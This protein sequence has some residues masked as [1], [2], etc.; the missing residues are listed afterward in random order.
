MNIIELKDE[1]SE[2]RMEKQSFLNDTYLWVSVARDAIRELPGE[3][4]IFKT[5]K[6]R[7]ASENKII[8]RENREKV[9]N[10]IINKD[11]FN[12]AFVT[13]IT[14]IEDYL[15]KIMKLILQFDSKRLKY[16]IQGVNMITNI[17]VVEFID[18]SREDM[19]N[20]IINQRLESLFYASPKKQ[21]EYLDK[22]L[23]VKLEEELW[24]KWIESKARRDLIVHNGGVV[25]D[26][27]LKKT[28]Q[29]ALLN[30]G[31][32]AIIDEDYF[33]NIIADLKR[34]IGAI[35]RLVRT[36]YSIPTNKEIKRYY[37]STEIV[38]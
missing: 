12:S 16:T 24:G 9:I 34:M 4:L 15:N 8:S 33:R 38:E 26:V 13:V 18:N 10:R 23:G 2:L 19:I 21:L 32:E 11:I 28:D 7:K 36:E 29:F 14:S 5:P 27:Y 22:G 3:K 20:N 25:N 35:D 31:E 37:S 1:I 30:F 17:P 6:A